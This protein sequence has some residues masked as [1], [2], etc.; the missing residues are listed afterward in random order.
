MLIP[1]YFEDLSTFHI[2]TLPRRNYFIPYANKD[3]ALH[4]NNRRDS[5]YY[6]DLNGTWNFHYFDNVREI[7]S[8]YWLSSYQSEIEYHSMTVPSV[9]ELAGY[10]QIQYSNTEFPIP[11]DPPYAPYETPGGLYN[12][13]FEVDKETDFNYHLN[14]EGVDA[15]FYV[16]VND[17]FIGYSQ[18]SHSNTEFDLSEAIQDGENTLSVLVIQWGDMTYLEDQ[19]KHR[20]S[21]IFRDVYLLKRHKNRINNFVVQTDVDKD[22]STAN[23]KFSIKDHSNISNY[24][25][26]LLDP[27]ENIVTTGDTSIDD[28]LSID[29]TEP[30][31]WDAENP[32]LY[33]LIVD[34]GNEVYIQKIGLRTI[35]VSNSKIYVN[36]QPIFLVG[37]NHHDTHPETGATVTLEDQRKDLEQMK[38]LNFNAIRTAHYPKTAEF[39]ELCDEMGFYVMS[40]AD[41]EAHGV[42]DLYGLGGSEDNYNM[43]AEDET[44]EEAIIDRMDASIVPFINFTSIFMWSAGNESGYGTNIEA[45]LSH[46]RDLDSSRLLHYEGYWERDRDKDH[47]YNTDLHD[48]W[49]RMYASFEEMDELYFSKPLDKPFILCEYIHAMGNSPGDVQDYHDYMEKHEEFAGG[50]VW[51]WA[52]HAVNINR[53]TGKEPAY[54]YG[55]DFGEYPHAGNFCMDGLVYPDRTPHTGAY[56]HRQVF[57]PVVLTDQNLKNNKVTLKNRYAFSLLNDKIDLVAELYNDK[58]SLVDKII[59]ETPEI[60]PY[61]EKTVILSKLD[62]IDNSISSV[63]LV[64]NMKDKDVE[65]GF[66]TITINEF[67]PTTELTETDDLKV[68]ETNTTFNIELDNREIQLSK[69]TGAIAQLIDNK[70]PLLEKPSSWTIW[71]APIDND[72]NIRKEW[73]QANYH[74]ARTRVHNWNIDQSK[75]SVKISFA[76]VI[77]AVSR[78]TIIKFEAH[79][80]ITKKGEFSLSFEGQKNKEQPFL[81]RFGLC[82]LLTNDMNQVSYFGNGPY[83]S[84]PDKKQA[85]YL[86]QFNG[87]V[88]DFYE[89][90]VTPQENGSHNDVRQLKIRDNYSLL[91]VTSSEGLSFNVSHFSVDQLTKIMH[92]DKLVEEPYTYLHLDYQQ[93][94]SGSNACGPELAE[95][96]RLNQDHFTFEFNFNF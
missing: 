68:T 39:Y 45:S 43:I 9:W 6:L 36:H 64:Y 22:L 7:E 14:F 53:G 52:D 16:W 83:E 38:E 19:D 87:S 21:G 25:Y 40:E 13:T 15:G 34:T 12:R 17:E 37:V 84:Y 63:R 32:H 1:N 18:I 46:A 8:P 86:A 58:G 76:G 73:E 92:R 72:R 56:E 50:F 69:A 74:H 10:G 71:R 41:L 42:V 29:I 60:N 65:L 4:S 80:K 5:A 57:R 11:F 67:T 54:R 30:I 91:D 90:Y 70:R 66:D 59:L 26:S 77:N 85:N 28:N 35:Y 44:Y 49:S 96:Y 31:L 33:T 27:S 24:T 78:H 20:Y 47:L 94:G 95:K 93:S 3:E 79:W 75:D 82:V 55:G 51:E 2:N 48:V 88:E 23:V 89:P 62:K 81:P 61:S